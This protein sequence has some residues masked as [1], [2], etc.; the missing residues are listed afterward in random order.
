M[1]VATDNAALSAPRERLDMAGV[2]ATARD[3]PEE[4]VSPS[5]LYWANALVR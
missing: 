1:E 4:P 2:S 5:A 3:Q